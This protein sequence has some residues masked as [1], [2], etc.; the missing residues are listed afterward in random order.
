MTKWAAQNRLGTKSIWIRGISEPEPPTGCFEDF[1]CDGRFDW[2]DA[3][4]EDFNPEPQG[5]P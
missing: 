5:C 4:P 1:D 2:D 3:C